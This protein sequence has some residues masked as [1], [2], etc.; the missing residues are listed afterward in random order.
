MM[1][2]SLCGSRLFFSAISFFFS[3]FVAFPGTLSLV[4][5]FSENP[6]FSTVPFQTVSSRVQTCGEAHIIT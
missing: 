6:H 1:T 4:D 2:D 5:K 3:F